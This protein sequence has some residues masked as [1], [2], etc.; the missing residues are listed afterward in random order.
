[1][2]SMKLNTCNVL[3]LLLIF[4]GAPLW[5]Q[6]KETKVDQTFNVNSN[7]T[8]FIDS[9][10]GKVHIETWNQSKIQAKVV[11]EVDGN[12]NTARD[13]LD[14][15]SI[16]VNESSSQVKL[17][18]EIAEARNSRNHRFKINYTVTMPEG[19]PLRIDHRHGDIYLGDHSGSL[20]LDL[21]HGQIVAEALTGD[22]RVSL[23]HGSGG[24]IS[25]LGSGNLEVQ[26]YQ[27]LRL[28]KLGD[29]DM[30][31]AHS[32]ADVENGGDIDLEIRHSN[33]EF[34]TVG[35]LTVD[36]QHSKLRAE[37]AKSVETDMQHSTVDIERVATAVS[38]DGNHSH[39]KV[40]RLSKNFSRVEFDGNHSYLGL[41][42]ESGAKGKLDVSL[43]HGKMDYPE[44]A[45]NMSLV[46]IENNSRSYRG[47]IGNGTGGTI[48]VEGNFTDFD[49]DID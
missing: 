34:E 37:S 22:S 38:A 12:E 43:H 8:L 36:M 33:L 1:M 42:L 39:V 44:S 30:E 21:A 29:M 23:Q 11:V 19:N 48:Q 4:T 25:S 27:R 28:G 24:R 6:I 46:N 49:L 14:R 31:L 16:D 47:N 26:H 41:G 5:G 35:E 7:T 20:D 15:I 13:I 45:V 32:S 17:E 2:K 9:K 10:F 40:G 3:F 18:T